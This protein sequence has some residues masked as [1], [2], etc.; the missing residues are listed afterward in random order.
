MKTLLMA[1]GCLA[2]GGVGA[3]VVGAATSA[4]ASID[5]RAAL[6]E[7][8]PNTQISAVDC[9]TIPGLCEVQAGANIV[10][11][12]PQARHLIVGRVYDMETKQDL[13]AARLLDLDPGSLV[14]GGAR[15]AKGSPPTSNVAAKVDLSVLPKGGAI[16]FGRGRDKLTVFSDF[17]CGYC[18]KLYDELTDMNVRVVERPI[19]ILGSRKLSESV[20]CAKDGAK[21]VQ[22]AYRG[23]AVRSADCDTSGL[24]ANEA[25]AKKNGFT[26]TPVIVREDGTVLQGYRDA[27]FLKRWVAEGR[28]K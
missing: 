24:D 15:A 5:T 11:V 1:L 13:T 12:D 21:A 25:F 8:L 3:L 14:A 16:T 18:K 20:L 19:S 2:F 7:R 4:S 28:A 23:E 22:A 10:Y 17:R 9:E 6:A 27:A 26:G